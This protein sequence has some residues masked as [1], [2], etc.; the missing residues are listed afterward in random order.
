MLREQLKVSNIANPHQNSQ[1]ESFFSLRK[2]LS[3]TS[4]ASAR[5]GP[6]GFTLAEVLV[7]GVIMAI[8]AAVA[9]P[10]YTSYVASQK[11]EVVKNLAQTAGISAN[12]FYRRY[13]RNPTKTEL[14]F[15]LPD[16][17]S[18]EIVISPDPA[19]TLTVSN[20][21]EPTIKL[22]VSFH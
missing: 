7:V 8:L 15:Y 4:N 11:Q 9:I 13:G 5:V 21:A 1:P 17:S 3:K 2:W 18:Y 19:A 22:T 12:A 6:R 20:T 14:N 10:F 16:P